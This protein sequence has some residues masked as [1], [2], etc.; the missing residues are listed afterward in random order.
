MTSTTD[1]RRIYD[2]FDTPI[3]PLDCG[4]MCAPH[5]PGG[6]PFCCDICHAVP[7]A[8]RAE[9]VYLEQNTELWHAWRGDECQQAPEDPAALQAQAPEQMLLLACKGPEQCQRRFR[10]ISCRQFPFFPYISYDLR[11]LGLAYEWEFEATCWVISHLELVSPAYREEF[12]RTFD[13]LFE[14]LPQ[15][16]ESY[17]IRSD[18]MRSHF[19]DQR[20]RIPLLHRNGKFYLV[21]PDSERLRVVSPTQFR[22]FGPYQ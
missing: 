16:L 9:W 1:F 19:S 13:E 3:L 14:A 5:N 12:I 20:R 4:T 2:H 22:R 7:A 17:A 15:E 10:A 18:E 6:K 11:F 8:Y 21:S